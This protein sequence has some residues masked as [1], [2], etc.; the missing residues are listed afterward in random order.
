MDTVNK[1]ERI[2]EW[3]KGKCVGQAFQPAIQYP[4]LRKFTNKDLDG[5]SQYKRRLPHWELAGSTYFIT[6]HVIEELGY[7]FMFVSVGQAF[8]PA[9]KHKS[10]GQ[11]FQPASKHKSVG[12]AFQPANL[13][14]ITNPSQG[15]HLASIVEESLWFGFG[16]RYSLDAYV[17]M[18]DHIHILITPIRGWTLAK[19]L[20][21]M[22]GFTAREI[23]KIMCRKGPFWQDEN[24]DH[25]IRDERDWLDKFDYIHRNPIESG[26]VERP[27]DYPF[28]SLVTIHSN[29]RLE[30]LKQIL[31]Q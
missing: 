7:P 17:V 1:R 29:G 25:L 3:L 10:V 22:K 13:I 16:E 24:F 12:Q 23:N 14:K 31:N 15:F 28:S 26:L 9:S 5:V 27:Q 4:E 30:S 6:S 8:Q 19:I 20:M 2:P 21:G 18:P 11:A